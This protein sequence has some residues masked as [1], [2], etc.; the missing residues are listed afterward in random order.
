[1]HY[2]NF[3][4]TI[5]VR[6]TSDCALVPAE[7]GVAGAPVANQATYADAANC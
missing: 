3:P 2:I 1:M 5:R 4:D 7:S 6:S